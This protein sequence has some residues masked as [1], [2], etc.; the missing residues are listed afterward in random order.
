MST[1][2]RWVNDENGYNGPPT[3]PGLQPWQTPVGRG[4]PQAGS[5]SYSPTPAPFQTSGAPSTGNGGPPMTAQPNTYTGDPNTGLVP[6]ATDANGNVIGPSMIGGITLGQTPIIPGQYSQGFLTDYNNYA[7]QVG[8]AASSPY[9]YNP[10]QM[11]AAQMNTGNIPQPTAQ[12]YGGSS[13]LNQLLSGQGYDPATLARMHAGA[14]DSVAGQSAM[15]LSQAR[16]ALGQAGTMDSPAGVG[17]QQD[18]ARQAGAAQ[19]QASNAIDINNA[20][21]GN[22]NFLAG[23]GMQNQN[24]ISNMQQANQM[25]LANANNLFQGMQQNT[26]N[27]QAANSASYSANTQRLGNQ[28]QAAS[29]AASQ[30]GN[31]FENAQ[32]GK[33]NTA[34]TT[35]AANAAAWNL[36][37]AQLNRQQAQNNQAV[38]ENRWNTAFNG[39]NNSNPTGA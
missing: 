23:V 15:Q 10:G 35:N 13:Q 8:N 26:Q 1:N 11:S 38:Q 27:Q 18:V 28:A 2:P 31:N 21:V 36:N 32:L 12:Q 37:S 25:A 34:D 4:T 39:T 9:N 3:A 33:Q 24:G 22:Q 30:A 7:A 19:T 6:G 14:T 29:S 20:Q 5:Y 17:V 16:Q